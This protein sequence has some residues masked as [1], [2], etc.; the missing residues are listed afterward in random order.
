MVFPSPIPSNIT[1][2]GNKQGH[3]PRLH[4]LTNLSL[5]AKIAVF[6]NTPTVQAADCN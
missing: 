3:A 2:M 4:I 5:T 1:H 6:L